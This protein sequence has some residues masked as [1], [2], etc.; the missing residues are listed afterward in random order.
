[1]NALRL[2]SSRQPYRRGGL[3]IGPKHAPTI[4]TH[5]DIGPDGLLKVLGDAAITVST[6][7]D[8]ET[9]RV[10]GPEERKAAL[11]ALAAHL[12]LDGEYEETAELVGQLLGGDETELQP[13]SGVSGEAGGDASS[14]VDPAA[15]SGASDDKGA[16]ENSPGTEPASAAG[17]EHSREEADAS[18][19]D[20]KA[21]ADEGNQP[22]ET[23]RPPVA[24]PVSDP[25]NGPS[26]AP[27]AA[28]PARKAQPKQ[29]TQDKA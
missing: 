19:A 16:P 1:V 27:A 29:A 21:D 14:P 20:R 5:N 25:N 12:T 24:E 6:S 7:D 26:A 22:E 4:V 2:S 17:A 3:A 8:G 10:V 13:A 11:D 9:W 18:A 28:K 23:S 15:S